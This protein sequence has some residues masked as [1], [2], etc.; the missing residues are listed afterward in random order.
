MGTIVMTGS[1]HKCCFNMEGC[2]DW[3]SSWNNSDDWQSAQVTSVASTWRVV[4]TGSH[5]ENDNDDW[6][7]AEKFCPASL[8]RASTL[9]ILVFG[10][11]S[12]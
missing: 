8:L 10:E 7:S 6:Q 1:Q 11:G 3:K 5:H 2:D 12:K 9:R 4:M